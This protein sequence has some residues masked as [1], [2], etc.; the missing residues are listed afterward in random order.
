MKKKAA[1]LR[2]KVA[3]VQSVFDDDPKFREFIHNG[4]PGTSAYDAHGV[5]PEK[6]KMIV[7]WLQIKNLPTKDAREE[8]VYLLMHYRRVTKFL[9]DQKV[10]AWLE[11]MPPKKK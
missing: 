6:A 10:K 1:E 2:E 11:L 9:K 7:D 8:A 4:V 3:E 5:P